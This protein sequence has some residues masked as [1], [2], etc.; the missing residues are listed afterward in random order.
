MSFLI[1]R[2][3]RDIHLALFN[4]RGHE[5]IDHR[6]DKR[7]YLESVNVGIGADYD[8]APTQLIDIERDHI[9]HRFRLDLDSAAENLYELGYDIVCKYFVIFRLEAVEYLS[10][11]GDHRLER[12]VAR[13][14]T[15]AESRVALH[16]EQ[17]ALGDI[18]AAAVNEFLHTAAHIVARLELAFYIELRRLSTDTRTHIDEHLIAYL[19]RIE[20][21]FDEI[22]LELMLEE[23]GHCLLN[24][25]VR[26]SFFR[27]VLI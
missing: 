18:L 6:E 23:L 22:H 10:A 3:L 4:K 25:L 19:V 9:F 27:L 5:A 7:A 17:L 2:R 15:G 13:L 26:D 1:K 14:L 16:Y 11:H 8:L 12:R 20:L 24:E 21:V